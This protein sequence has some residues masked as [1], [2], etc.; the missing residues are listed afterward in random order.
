MTFAGVSLGCGNFGG[1]GSSPAFFGQGIP[2]D[3]AFAI[4]DRAYGAGI[5]WFD[6]GDAYG[7]GSSESWIGEWRAARKPE[8]LQLT[9]KV[10]HS[11][12]GDPDDT[13]LEPDRIRRQLESSLS[14]LGVDRVDLYLAH[15]P[16]ERVP[17]ADT[18]ACF[19]SLRAEGLIGAWGSATTTQT[20]SAR[21][22]GTVRRRWY[23][24][25]SRCS[26]ATTSATRFRPAT[27][28]RSR[29]CRSGR[30]RAVG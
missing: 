27:T 11:T 14:R 20:A 3:E 17:L 23:R 4:M 7:G 8:R 5:H 19:E 15:E 10:F 1:I 26:T 12:V 18:I 13:G 28:T 29:P 30:S 9:T 22:C 25:R 16:D 2:H 6:T 21:R 24:T